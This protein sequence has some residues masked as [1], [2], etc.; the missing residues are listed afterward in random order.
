MGT[1]KI[2]DTTMN[3][4]EL[5]GPNAE[6]LT[7][8]TYDYW[9]V[10]G[11]KGNQYYLC[12]CICGKL[13]N[14]H[15][16]SLKSCS[17]LSCGCMQQRRRG[18]RK[19]SKVD[20]YTGQ[21]FGDWEVLGRHDSKK[22]NCKC[23]HCGYEKT[24]AVY[25]LEH[26][27]SKYCNKC[28]EANEQIHIGDQIFDWT[29]IGM[30]AELRKTGHVMC[31]CTCGV[32]RP[33]SKARL[34]EGKTKHCGHKFNN[35]KEIIGT[36]INNI[37]VV[38]Q[39]GTGNAGYE[40]QCQLCGHIFSTSYKTLID[41]K[42]HCQQCSPKMN[43][44]IVGKDFGE[45]HV[46]K[47]KGNGFVECQ[48]SCGCIKNV[49]TSALRSGS[50][51]SCG[52][53]TTKLKDITG[54]T[55][56]DWLV[57]ERVGDKW[58]CQCK[59]GNTGIVTGGA[60]RSGRSQKCT[61]CAKNRLIDLT[62]QTFGDWTVISRLPGNY[63][64]CRCSCGN[65]K[66]VSG[67]SLTA[68]HSKSCGC[69]KV[70][71]I[72]H[73]KL[74]SNT[75]IS[76]ED[77]K[78]KRTTDQIEAVSSKENLT[79]FI[80]NIRHKP[81]IT[82]LANLLGISRACTLYKV[83]LYD[84]FKF[85]DYSEQH[86][87]Q[88]ELWIRQYVRSIYNGQIIE[89]YKLPNKQEIDIFIPDKNIGIEVN[90]A[91]FH[92]DYFK[93]PLYHQNKTLEC[94]K[95]YIYLIHI[96][97][98]EWDNTISQNIIKNYLKQMINGTEARYNKLTLEINSQD[99]DNIINYLNSNSIYNTFYSSNNLIL[100][101]DNSNIVLYTDYFEDDNGGIELNDI[102]YKDEYF[103]K[104]TFRL[105]WDYLTDI[106]NLITLTLDVSHGINT[107]YLDFGFETN[108]KLFTYPSAI[109]I[110]PEKNWVVHEDYV[111]KEELVDDY[112][113]DSSGYLKVYNSGKLQYIYDVR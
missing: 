45:W 22:V 94:A 50:S 65:E 100:R 87:S 27:R 105:V 69:K 53:N 13:K 101:D 84:L 70:Y 46:I 106:F 3:F 11:Y 109:W 29:V 83:K 6:D 107:Q 97:E 5:T 79:N 38:R 76:E 73:T 31:R 36:V 44:N 1:P 111:D 110:N 98:N 2:N 25:S 61:D 102:V 108:R 54:Q 75:N 52:H 55:F 93:E 9:G 104:Q 43:Y 77:L 26:G 89:H 63:Y 85:V 10:L 24:I 28:K 103:N 33:V 4:V 14:V 66:A 47:Y 90:G 64:K 48:C 72:R 86:E 42:I 92:S 15:A 37:K 7:G 32:E 88:R 59:C 113:M 74:G 41:K 17:S 80:I 12:R 82:E 96:L 30:P 60:L 58:L 68:G 95:N 78:D 56:G 62:G 23:I 20:S 8:N 16:Y 57:L 81:T 34:I 91:Y 35:R 21:V 49:K 112:T 40:C 71:Y 19:N 39:K 67:Y 18:I 99:I 51:K